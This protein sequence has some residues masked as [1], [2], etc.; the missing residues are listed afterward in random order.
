MFQIE[1]KKYKRNEKC[2]QW[3][4]LPIELKVMISNGLKRPIVALYDL[5]CNL[6]YIMAK[7]RF[8]WT[9]IVFSRGHRSKLIWSCFFK[10]KGIKCLVHEKENHEWWLKLVRLLTWIYCKW[11]SA[12]VSADFA[13]AFM[14]GILIAARASAMSGND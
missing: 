9:W 11:L 12:K 6:W 5:V 2:L 8:D 3:K 7:Y 13:F 10:G 14:F 4:L 1:Q